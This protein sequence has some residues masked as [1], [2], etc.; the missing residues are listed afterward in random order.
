M[1]ESTVCVIPARGGSKRVPRK[2]VMPIAGVPM[3]ARTIRTVAESGIVDRIVVS[4]DDDEIAAVSSDAGAEVPFRRP[5]ELSD[6]HTPTVPVV[7]HALRALT[8]TGDSPGRVLVIYATAV[9]TTADD[10]RAAVR[11]ADDSQAPLVMSVC[12]Y[13]MPIERAW[14]LGADGRGDIIHP[15]H[16]LTRTQDLPATYHDAGQFYLGTH[17]FWTSGGDIAG[18]RPALLELPR[19]RAID[20]D[21]PDDLAFVEHLVRTAGLDQT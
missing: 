2:N 9:M 19:H 20:I 7:A 4:T 14:H 1:A 11:L 15:E 6:D 16:A 8:A 13:P 3:I 21:T 10:L 12:R 18:A 5:P 17:G